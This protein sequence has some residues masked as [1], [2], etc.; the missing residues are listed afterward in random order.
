V[1]DTGCTKDAD[2]QCTHTTNAECDN[3]E[4]GAKCKCSD[5]YAEDRTNG[6][7]C[8]QSKFMRINLFI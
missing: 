7:T 2:D 5:G 4:T 6:K 1:T 3:A 8:V